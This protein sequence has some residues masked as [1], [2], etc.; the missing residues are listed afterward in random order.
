M[1]FRN[2]NL[3]YPVSLLDHKS[4]SLASLEDKLTKRILRA[5]TVEQDHDELITTHKNR[6]SNWKQ[7][8]K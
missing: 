4:R 7:A 8:D 6:I 3:H 1:A 2:T 5:E